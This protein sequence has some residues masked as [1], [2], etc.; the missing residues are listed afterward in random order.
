MKPA[1]KIEKLIKRLHF[2]ASAEMHDRTLNDAVEAQAKSKKTKPAKIEPSIWRTIMKSRMRKLVAAVVVIAVLIGVYQFA[3]GRAAFA[4]T[5]RAVRFTLSRLKVMILEN[6][7]RSRDLAARPARRIPPAG[8][9]GA[10]KQSRRIEGKA[11][12]TDIHVFQIRGRQER[13]TDFFESQG[14]NF[15][16]TAAN[17]DVS[18]AVLDSE[19]L[20][21]FAAFLESSDVLK[22][23]ASPT[24]EFLEGREA[25]IASDDFGVALTGTVQEDNEKVDLS[26]AFLD[27]QAGFKIPSIT[28]EVDQAVLIRGA[29]GTEGTS[30]ILVLIQVE[31]H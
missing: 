16:P 24:L 1:E 19:N 6:R 11:I 5:T 28:I 22:V 3:G 31:V 4:Q 9:S 18:C 14:I 23:T 8:D 30:D 17:P 27:G 2:K 21:H 29:K 25:V 26:F 15:D 13:L 12:R 10:G 7:A 20:E